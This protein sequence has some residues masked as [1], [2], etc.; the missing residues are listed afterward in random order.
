MLSGS[1]S[2]VLD[3]DRIP[4]LRQ[5]SSISSF[6]NPDSKHSWVTNVLKLE[7]SPLCTKDLS[8]NRFNF[9]NDS[10]KSKMAAYEF[11][12]INKIKKNLIDMSVDQS[13]NILHLSNHSGEIALLTENWQVKNN[14][15]NTLSK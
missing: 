7:L 13:N 2:K 1:L 8:S 15:K 3:S 10:P 4:A 6:Q 5:I 11:Y 12:Q 9:S 14:V